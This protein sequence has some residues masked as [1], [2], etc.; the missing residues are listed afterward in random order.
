MIVFAAIMPHPLESVPGIG[1]PADFALI[2]KTLQSFEQLR[3]DL[4]KAQPDTIIIISPHAY[5]EKYAFVINSQAE[6]K[7][8]LENFGLDKV[9][10][11]ENNIK[12]SDKIGYACT[13]SDMVCQ[14][15]GHFLDHGALIPLYHL[16]KNIKP[17]VVHLSFSM[18]SY[19][20]HYRYGEIV[21]SIIDNNQRVA[22]VASGDLSHGLNEK[23]STG[24]I[25]GAEEFD[26][27]VMRYLGGNDL[28]SLMGMEEEFVL[29]AC[30]C[31][32]RSIIILLGILHGKKY[33]FKLLSYEGPLGIGYLTAKLL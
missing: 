25:A 3:I 9:F 18:M 10:E 2:K 29:H 15:H 33:K 7:G 22:I 26:H 27:A 4:E 28:A 20:R 12:I 31:G 11:Y 14:L 19:E 13:M 8:S 23:S 30:E 24:Y 17:K 1:G 5:M 32:I 16:T 6:L 21:Q